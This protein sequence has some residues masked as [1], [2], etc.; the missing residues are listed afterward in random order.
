MSFSQLEIVNMRARTNAGIKFKLM[1]GEWI[2]K[3]PEG[4]INLVRIEARHKAVRYIEQSPTYIQAI[5]SAW[6]IL[7]LDN[8]TL[9]DICL[10]LSSKG[11]I[12]SSGKAWSWVNPKTAAIKTARDTLKSIFRN[13]FYAGWVTSKAFR[14]PDG[15]NPRQLGTSS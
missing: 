2:Y 15:T 14:N 9:D 11:Y 1:N 12:R 7:L 3:A 10:A 6:E 5:K 13:P 4:Y 8:F